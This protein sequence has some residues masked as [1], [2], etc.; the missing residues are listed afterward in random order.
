MVSEPEHV[1]DI[2]KNATQSG[3]LTGDML[4]IRTSVGRNIIGISRG[5]VKKKV[6]IHCY[7]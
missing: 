1:Q 2:K 5:V 7:V 4:Y 3:T 6:I